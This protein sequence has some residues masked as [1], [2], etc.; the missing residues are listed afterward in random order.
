MKQG[1]KR[2]MSICLS[3]IPKDRI[4][5]HENGKLYLSVQTYDYDEPDRFDNDFSISCSKTKEEIEKSKAG[6]KVNL[7]FIG[8]GRI[9]EDNDAMKPLTE[10]EQAD[11]DWLTGLGEQ[12]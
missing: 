1:R 8:N 2:T 5:K 12:P 9:W 7:H 11:L 4:L 6:E 3:D 10:K